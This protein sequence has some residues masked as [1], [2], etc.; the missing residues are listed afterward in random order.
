MLKVHL[1]HVIVIFY[2]KYLMKQPKLLNFKI[3]RPIPR[4]NIKRGSK[5]PL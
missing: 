5:L 4:N 1:K 3:G 2:I